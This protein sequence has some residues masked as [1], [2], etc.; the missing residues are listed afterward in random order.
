MV[1]R[2]SPGDLPEPSSADVAAVAEGR[3]RQPPMQ[4]CL[5]HPACGGPERCTDCRPNDGEVLNERAAGGVH[6]L[7]SRKQ[8]HKLYT[9]LGHLR[10]GLVGRPVLWSTKDHDI[11]VRLLR[12]AGI[13]LVTRTQAKIRGHLIDQ[14]VRPV[15]RLQKVGKLEFVALYLFGVQTQPAGE[16]AST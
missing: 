15:V 8:I 14:A 12:P 13:E 6:G 10:E 11:A 9:L 5:R 7:L 1:T 4:L 2:E 16:E 3:P